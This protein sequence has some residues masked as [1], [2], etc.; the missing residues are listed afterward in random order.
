[1]FLAIGLSA[2]G[3][4]TDIQAGTLNGTSFWGVAVLLVSAFLIALPFGLM[5]SRQRVRW[6]TGRPQGTA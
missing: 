1:M 3:V 5:A 2:F 6:M 4:T